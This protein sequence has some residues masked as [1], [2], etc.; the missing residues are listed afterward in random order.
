MRRGEEMRKMF[1]ST[2][3]VIAI[4]SP[5]TALLTEQ[6]PSNNSIANAAIQMPISSADNVIASD[7]GVLTF[8]AGGGD[9]DYIGIGPLRAGDVIKLLTT[10][11][12]DPPAFETPDTILGLFDSNGAVECLGDDAFNNDLDQFPTGFGSLCRYE[13]SADGDYYAGTTGFSAAPFDGSHFEEGLYSITI[14]VTRLPE[15]GVVLQLA[16]GGLGLAALQAR[17]RRTGR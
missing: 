12:G 16:F 4:A 5:A 1:L 8:G 2:L 10:P 7:E 15:P 3:L 13:I 17:R 14:A 11:L 9:I 6:E